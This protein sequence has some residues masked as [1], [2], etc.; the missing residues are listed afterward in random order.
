MKNGQTVILFE[1]CAYLNKWSTLHKV[2]LPKIA[3]PKSCPPLPLTLAY[4]R[5]HRRTLTYDDIMDLKQ[6][7]RRAQW[8]PTGSVLTKPATSAHVSDVVHMAF[9]TWHLLIYRPQMNVSIQ[10]NLWRFFAHFILFNTNVWKKETV[11]VLFTEGWAV[12]GKISR[13]FR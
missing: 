10:S 3:R 6:P 11:F 13:D 12:G 7:G 9:R 1:G 4:W 5:L 8:T 2:S